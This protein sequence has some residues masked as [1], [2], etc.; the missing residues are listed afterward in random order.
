M[1]N[2]KISKITMVA[3]IAVALFFDGI[4]F[5]AGLINFIPFVGFILALVITSGVSIFAW[6]TFFLWFRLAGS[7]FDSKIVSTTV[8]TF[9]IE[10]IP[11]LNALPAWTLSI[12]VI[13]IFFQTKKILGDHF[14]EASAFIVGKVAKDNRLGQNQK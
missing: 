14:P 3:M 11:I 7:K 6:L 8:G 2:E 9:F 13:F 12:V 10:L 4:Q 5:A 1:E